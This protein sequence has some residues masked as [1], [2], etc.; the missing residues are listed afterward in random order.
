MKRWMICG[1]GAASM[2][3]V[4]GGGAPPPV[5]TEARPN[6][7]SAPVATA[8]AATASTGAPVVE[9]ALAAPKRLA[10]VRFD[11]GGEDFG[12]PLVDVVVGGHPT[13][14]MVDTGA[15]HHVI[16]SWVA[17]QLGKTTTT[18]TAGLDHAGKSLSLSQMVG[19]EIVVSGWGALGVNT[20]LVAT[21]PPVLQAQ[22]VGGVLSP[23]AMRS[24]G[25]AVV[26]DMRRG[27]LS[28]MG[29]EDALKGLES[30]PGEGF[31]GEVLDCGNGGS[32]A[33]V[34]ATIGGVAVE[35]QL[36]TGAT[37]TTVRA[38]ADVGVK[39]KP[40]AKGKNSAYAASGIFT[41]PSVET[42]SVQVGGVTVETSVDLVSR[43]P[44]T[45]CT[46]D[47]H[48]GMDVLRRCTIVMAEKTFAAKCDKPH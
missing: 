24:E 15:T 5:T 10:K 39:L 45:P 13:S 29:S 11:V 16:G 38:A 44:R 7:A 48:I 43:D 42:A 31:S 22:G 46:N 37:N 19:A 3:A 30:Q 1:L 8:E 20:V 28:E 12:V 26:L 2:G 4:G 33:F 40:L 17:A 34:K 18:G 36:D 25:R 41:V 23:L 27:T 21:L 47:A 6:V 14:L 35:A 32:L 9:M